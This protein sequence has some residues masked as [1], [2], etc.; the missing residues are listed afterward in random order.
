VALLGC[1][2]CSTISSS[3]THLRFPATFAGWATS[4]AAPFLSWRCLPRTFSPSSRSFG[5]SWFS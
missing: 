5:H 3:S 4:P 2:A 1:A